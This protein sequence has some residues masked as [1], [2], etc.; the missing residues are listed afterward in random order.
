[1]C[2]RLLWSGGPTFS[3]ISSSWVVGRKLFPVLS[4]R[5]G[6]IAIFFGE[7]NFNFGIEGTA[8]TG[9]I[10]DFGSKFGGVDLIA[11]DDG[12]GVEGFPAGNGALCVMDEN[13]DG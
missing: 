9:K 6:R 10:S 13:R 1:M 2:I 7:E 8:V 5:K 12:I 4:P 11:T 3:P